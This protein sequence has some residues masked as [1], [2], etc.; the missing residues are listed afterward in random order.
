MARRMVDRESINDV[1][2][3]MKKKRNVFDDNDPIIDA[4]GF[5]F[6]SLLLSCQRMKPCQTLPG[7]LINPWKAMAAFTEA[8]MIRFP[9]ASSNHLLFI[10][11]NFFQ[12][13]NISC[14]ALLMVLAVVVVRVVT[15]GG[16]WRC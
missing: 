1:V 7:G 6:T 3:E 8:D 4:P 14:C 11:K 9:Q 13:F 10:L 12:A 15:D 16:D 2:L 5:S